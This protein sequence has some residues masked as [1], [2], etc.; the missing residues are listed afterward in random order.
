MGKSRNA[1][2][3]RLMSGISQ[4]ANVTTVVGQFGPGPLAEV[5][6]RSILLVSER[7]QR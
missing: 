1:E 5:A 7:P 6:G 3:V 4:S 2:L